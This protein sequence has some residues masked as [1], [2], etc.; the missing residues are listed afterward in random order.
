MLWLTFSPWCL[1]AMTDAWRRNRFRALVQLQAIDSK[2]WLSGGGPDCH[3]KSPPASS[4]SIP[5]PSDSDETRLG[6]SNLRASPVLMRVNAFGLSAGRKLCAKMR[7]SGLLWPLC[8]G[9]ARHTSHDHAAGRRK[10][11]SSFL[12]SSIREEI[13]SPNLYFRSAALHHAQE[14]A[15][16]DQRPDDRALP[17]NRLVP[18]MITAAMA[19]SS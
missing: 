7:L 8:H 19:L 17:P 16:V 13:L 4:G 10:P 18:P 2:G 3:P 6:T 12:N 15:G 14:F 1:R 11:K 9:N 5:Y